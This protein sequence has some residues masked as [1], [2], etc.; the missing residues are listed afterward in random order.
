MRLQSGSVASAYVWWIT[1]GTVCMQFVCRVE[2]GGEQVRCQVN[3]TEETRLLMMGEC[4]GS[5][6]S[7]WTLEL[8]T[9][10]Q[11]VDFWL[12]TQLVPDWL[13]TWLRLVNNDSW[14]A[15]ALQRRV[16]T[17]QFCRR[18]VMVFVTLCNPFMHHS[19]TTTT[20]VWRPNKTQRAVLEWGSK[21][22]VGTSGYRDF[23][24][25]DCIEKNQPL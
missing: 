12:G 19:M 23:Q 2:Q 25:L 20:G 24:P 17:E 3:T 16:G 6:Y 15:R 1:P 11:R 4:P 18:K 22:D 7:V 14:A 8:D 13:Q 21:P 9:P 5:L 10:I